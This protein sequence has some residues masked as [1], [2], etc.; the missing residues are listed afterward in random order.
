MPDTP[1]RPMP[2]HRLVGDPASRAAPAAGVT[3]ATFVA[4]LDSIDA[5]RDNERLASWPMTAARRQSWHLE[6]PDRWHRTDAGTM[7]ATPAYPA[8][9][10]PAR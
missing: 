5:L 9:S 7:P 6:V 3:Q 10:Y 8:R 1:G 4:P 2:D